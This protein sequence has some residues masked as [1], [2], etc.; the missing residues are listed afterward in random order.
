[1]GIG[2]HHISAA[3]AWSQTIFSFTDFHLFHDARSWPHFMT[4]PAAAGIAAFITNSLGSAL[5]VLLS[6]CG[7]YSVLPQTSFRWLNFML[8][9][10]QGSRMCPWGEG[11]FQ[12]T[13]SLWSW[14]NWHQ[15]ATSRLLGR[16]SWNSN[17]DVTHFQNLHVCAPLISG[18]VIC[19]C[20]CCVAR[21]LRDTASCG[22]PLHHCCGW[23]RKWLFE[24]PWKRKRKGKFWYSGLSPKLACETPD[25]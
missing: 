15:C 12:G 1:M 23:G 10:S 18:V 17:R 8:K 24:D 2:S 22:F 7:F 25:F 13:W 3:W 4:A 14:A 5:L 16:N 11:C 9:L 20:C 6:P 21:V 19:R